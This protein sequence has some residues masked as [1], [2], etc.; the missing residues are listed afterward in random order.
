[1]IIRCFT[2]LIFY[3]YRPISLIGVE[4]TAGLYSGITSIKFGRGFSQ[5]VDNILPNT[6][7]HLTFNEI[8]NNP[9]DALPASITHLTFGTYFNQSADKLPC[10]VTHLTF[11]R[12]FNQR[13]DSLPPSVC[14]LSIGDWWRRIEEGGDYVTRISAFNQ[15]VDALPRAIKR[16]KLL[17]KFNQPV[18]NLPPSI[19]RLSFGIK[20]NQSLEHLPKSITHLTVGE[21]F[22]RPET[23]KLTPLR[24]KVKSTKNVEEFY[25]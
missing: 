17:G 2:P 18:D 10:S 24:Y 20:F 4:S 16:V 3:K 12:Y 13:V 8:F 5:S 1:M 25:D 11:G 7:T 22:M 15:P 19:T 23:I 14:Y 9:V 6:L 21:R